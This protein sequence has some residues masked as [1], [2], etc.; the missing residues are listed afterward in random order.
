MTCKGDRQMPL[1]RMRHSFLP[2]YYQEFACDAGAQV[3]MPCEF[4]TAMS[5]KG[6]EAANTT[7]SRI[8][9]PQHLSY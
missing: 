8:I 4:G 2:S 6:P 3:A 7:G 9:V 1:D 5:Q